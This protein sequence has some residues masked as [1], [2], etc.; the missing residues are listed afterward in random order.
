MDRRT[1]RDWPAAPFDIRRSKWR[2]N[3]RIYYLKSGV[4]A[5]EDACDKLPVLLW[6]RRVAIF[7]V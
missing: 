6:G 1:I 5:F 4:Q 3:S 2:P 7:H